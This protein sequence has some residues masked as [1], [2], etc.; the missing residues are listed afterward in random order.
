MLMEFVFSVVAY[1]PA[2]RKHTTQITTM[3]T[4]A[5]ITSVIISVPKT[6]KKS[7]EGTV[8]CMVHSFGTEY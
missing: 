5:D 8:T 2:E 3:H 6:V 1:P 4:I 7:Y